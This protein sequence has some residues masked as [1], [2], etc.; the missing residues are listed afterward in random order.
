MLTL[1]FIFL[2]GLFKSISDTIRV[3]EVMKTSIWGK[4]TG[5]EFI[6][7]QVSWVSLNFHLTLFL[8]RFL[9]CGIYVKLL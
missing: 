6:D 2:A 8:H 9:I 5:N 7:P 3:P 1:L 4:F